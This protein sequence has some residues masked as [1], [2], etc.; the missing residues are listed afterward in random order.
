MQE[1]HPPLPVHPLAS[2]LEQEPAHLNPFT[3]IREQLTAVQACT[4][5]RQSSILMP[6]QIPPDI[7]V[8]GPFC[9]AVRKINTARKQKTGCHFAL[10]FERMDKKDL[11]N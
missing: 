6:A 4:I 3:A 2:K 1:M 7:A 11:C 10:L 9:R 5:V 8:G